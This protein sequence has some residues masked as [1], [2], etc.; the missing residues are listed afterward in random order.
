MRGLLH[1]MRGLLHGRAWRGRAWRGRAP[2]SVRK[3]LRQV[4]V[5]SGSVSRKLREVQKMCVLLSMGGERGEGM[6]GRV[7]GSEEEGGGEEEGEGRG[8]VGYEGVN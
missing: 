8:A 3:R 7:R 5:A 4:E 1:G 2:G 6:R